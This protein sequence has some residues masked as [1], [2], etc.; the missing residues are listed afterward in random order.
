MMIGFFTLD[1]T[2]SEFS[3]FKFI[4][5]SLKDSQSKLS[6]DNESLLSSKNSNKLIELRL[7]E[8]FIVVPPRVWTA[9]VNWYGRTPEIKRK[10]IQYPKR[11]LNTNNESRNNIRR[12]DDE[13]VTEIEVDMIYVKFG[14]F[15]EDGKKPKTSEETYIS[16]KSTLLD[17]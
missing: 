7:N 11:F 3:L 12:I 9:F 5:E 14:L 6:I 17:L 16:R 1:L 10:T 15:T 8:N 13:T 2:V 4:V